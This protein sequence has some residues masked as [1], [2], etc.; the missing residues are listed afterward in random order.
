MAKMGSK[1]VQRQRLSAPV[2]PPPIYRPQTPALPVQTKTIPKS[3]WQPGTA[4]PV[5]RPHSAPIQQPGNASLQKKEAKAKPVVANGNYVLQAPMPQA[6][7]VQQI[8]VALPGVGRVGSV[9]LN[10]SGNGRVYI[11]DLQVT[12]EH[13]RLG[14]GSM[15]VQAALRTAQAQ[16]KTGAVLEAMPGGGSISPQAL[17]SMYQRLGFRQVGL[18]DRGRP[19]M[20]FGA[21]AVRQGS[22]SGVQLKPAPNSVYQPRSLIIQRSAM[23]KESKKEG[24]GEGRPRRST[25]GQR[26]LF[27]PAE[28][29]KLEMR[30]WA[31]SNKGTH[32]SDSID[33]FCKILA[34]QL[35]Q[36]LK[37]TEGTVAVAILTNGTYVAARLQSSISAEQVATSVG[38]VEQAKS[39]SL[40]VAPTTTAAKTNLHAEMMIWLQHGASMM[41][42]AA[43]RPCCKLCAKF[44]ESKGIKYPEIGDWPSN[45]WINPE[46][47]KAY[48]A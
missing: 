21:G 16:G 44:L 29:V 43:S 33:V 4:P 19:L 24:E 10:P 17:V 42:V 47:N 39:V 36:D 23:E 13:R 22:R 30:A 18:S 45:G 38:K 34:D 27:V 3:V 48:V 2:S 40:T 6:G 9:R 32:K 46:T 28:T 25:A 31:N 14:V 35:A 8:H 7:G 20:E 5:Y 11:S 1:S 37:I 15:L 12:P 26:E 41:E